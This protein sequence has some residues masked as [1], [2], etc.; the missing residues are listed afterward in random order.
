LWLRSYPIIY[1]ANNH[2]KTETKKKGRQT[3][4]S[5]AVVTM[6]RIG[7]LRRDLPPLFNQNHFNMRSNNDDCATCAKKPLTAESIIKELISCT[8]MEYFKKG[9]HDLFISWVSHEEL[10]EGEYKDTVIYTYTCL[11]ELLESVNQFKNQQKS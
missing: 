11:N 9:L 5:S 10:T 4:E 7:L 8:S 1:G 6:L 2:K 3:D